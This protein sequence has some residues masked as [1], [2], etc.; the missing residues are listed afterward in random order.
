MYLKV[1]NTTE[2][3]SYSVILILFGVDVVGHESYYSFELSQ[4]L[5]HG[6]VPA[7]HLL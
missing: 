2:S 4:F 3:N 5:L 7:I 6:V 1:L